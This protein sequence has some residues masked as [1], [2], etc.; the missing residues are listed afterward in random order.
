MT[1][2]KELKRALD[3]LALAHAADYLSQHDKEALLGAMP[4][5]PAPQ[6]AGKFPSPTVVPL[7]QLAQVALVAD[8]NLPEHLLDYALDTCRHFNAGLLLIDTLPQQ[9]ARLAAQVRQV[10]AADIALNVTALSEATLP[11]LHELALNQPRL[12]FVIMSGAANQALRLPQ[13]QWQSPAPL[14]VVSEQAPLHT[15]AAVTLRS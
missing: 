10:K 9:S 4:A 3:A 13:M 14:V 8:A 1:L 2:T 6:P 12:L 5:Q 7:R 15:P 11:A